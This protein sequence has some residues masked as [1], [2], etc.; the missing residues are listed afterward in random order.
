MVTDKKN[1][2]MIRVTLDCQKGNK[3]KYATHEPIPTPDELRHDL[4]G[5]DRFSV[6]DMTNCYYVTIN[7]RLRNLQGNYLISDHLGVFT[8]SK[9]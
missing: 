6:L 9:V 3:V 2:Y 4:C 7:L 8:D 1:T 5:R